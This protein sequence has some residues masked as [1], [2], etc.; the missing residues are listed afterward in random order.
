MAEPNSASPPTSLPLQSCRPGWGLSQGRSSL[1]SIP[2]AVVAAG[3][4]RLLPLLGTAPCSG[5]LAAVPV[6]ELP[7]GSLQQTACKPLP[8]S[9]FSWFPFADSQVVSG[10]SLQSFPGHLGQRSRLSTGR[11]EQVPSQPCHRWAGQPDDV[12]YR[13]SLGLRF[14]FC[15]V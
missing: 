13:F 5:P 4:G 11:K 3:T 9:P 7:Q 1:C 14:P 8:P 10:H 6:I 2:T 12:T 15:T